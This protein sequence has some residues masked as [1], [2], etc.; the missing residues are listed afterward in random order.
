MHIWADILVRELVML[1]AL[2]ALGSG[3]A[4]LLGSRFEAAARI[5]MAPVLGLC[6]GACVFTT[7][8]WF[9]AAQNTYWLVPI[10]ALLSVAAA[11]WR[12]LA[13]QAGEQS[14]SARLTSLFR[15]VRPRD[16][17]ALAVVCIVVATPLSYTLHERHSVG[18]IGYEVWD[19]VDYAAE[20]DA[21]VQES[22]RQAT[23][24]PSEA[25]FQGFATGASP[26]SLHLEP[27]SYNST[28]LFWTFYASGEQNLDVGPLSANLNQLIGLHGTDTQSPFLI[29][30]LVAGALGAFA[31]MRYAAPKPSW[32]APLA[33]V[34]FAGPLFLQ[35]LADGSQAATCGLAVIL[36]I[37]AVG[38][39]ALRGARWTSLVVLALLASGLMALYPIFVPA[40]A[41]SGAVLIAIAGAIGW[42]Q[43]RLNKQKLLAAAGGLGLVVALSILFNLVSFLRDLRYWH[44]VL[45]GGYFLSSLP[46]YHLPYSVLPGWLL[47][48]RE[49]Y[50]LTELGSTSA[51]EVLIGVVLPIL[52]VAVI[53]SGLKRRRASLMLLVPVLIY[54]VM[55]AYTSASHGCS[56]CTDRALLPIAPLSIGLLVL[57]IAALATAPRLWLRCA[58]IAV[59]IVAVIAVAARTRQ[60]RLRFANGAYF[61]DS[62]SRGLLSHLP[63]HAGSV[64]VEGYAQNPGKAP[65]EL[66][67]TYYLTS[68]RNHEEVSIPTE[69][70]DYAGLT[71]IGPPNP[72]NPQFDPN[73]RYILTRLG[74]VQTGRRVIARSGSLALEERTGPL[75]ATLVSGVAVPFVRLNANGLAWV[76]GPLHMLVVGGTSK[77]AWISLSFKAIVPVTIP[78]QPGVQAQVSPD[79]VISA[80]VRAT[81]A[82]PVRK[83]TI[84]LSFPLVPGA[85]PDE[86]FALQEPPQ[87]VQLVAMRAV[88]SCSLAGGR[89]S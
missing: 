84:A 81:G 76:E 78:R 74:G 83:G 69:S 58:G 33:G 29:V 40:I 8:I 70:D 59:A 82:L 20:P 75:D 50:S 31:A 17:L 45:D 41:L 34:L 60:E 28:R 39:D 47:Q 46:Q 55:A 87:G 10:L 26:Q 54:G 72:A 66:P 73:Y 35:L 51:K 6:V 32:A 30:F 53:F 57:G 22:I 65:G 38:A 36:P 13:A 27:S 16:L 61:L 77:P 85:I 14:L 88:N 80:C 9:T 4:S 49:F 44:K 3:P 24:P 37:L 43:G 5:A 67:L 52:F 23:D 71:Y 79:G 12:S 68:E 15:R 19:E 89:A 25:A 7:L 42:R 64:D 48:T 18:P 62:G 11:L 63:A 21:M 2:L 56:Y 1:V 86:P